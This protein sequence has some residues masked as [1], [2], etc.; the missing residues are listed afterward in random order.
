[1]ELPCTEGFKLLKMRHT[2]TRRDH[3]NASRDYLKQ[4]NDGQFPA[5]ARENQANPLK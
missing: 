4:P 1:M 5:L 3:A 2:I